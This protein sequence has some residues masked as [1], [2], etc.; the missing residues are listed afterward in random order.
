MIREDFGVLPPTM[1]PEVQRARERP[2]SYYGNLGMAIV[3]VGATAVVAS[4]L[5]LGLL[6]VPWVFM[7]TNPTM[8]PP[9]APPDAY[10]DLPTFL[11]GIASL[12]LLV[13][14]V[15]LV[16]GLAGALV[17]RQTRATTDL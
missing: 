15:T 11:G 14:I 6:T 12:S 16:V 2:P 17:V 13:G 4:L 8:G 5:T 1:S 10:R 9:P 7:G 3:K